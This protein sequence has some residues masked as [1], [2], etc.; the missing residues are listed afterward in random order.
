MNVRSSLLGFLLLCTLAP[1][2]A[3]QTP[4]NHLIAVLQTST[5]ELQAAAQLSS[6]QQAYAVVTRIVN[7]IL[8]AMQRMSLPYYQNQLTYLSNQQI[9]LTNRLSALQASV[10]NNANMLFRMTGAVSSSLAAQTANIGSI[11]IQ[12]KNSIQPSIDQLS[13]AMDGLA[14][15][16]PA[17]QSQV[18]SLLDLSQ[19]SITSLGSVEAALSDIQQKVTAAQS[20]PTQYFAFVF[21]ATPAT[22]AAPCKAVTVNINYPPGVGPFASPVVTV[23]EFSG[24]GTPAHPVPVNYITIESVSSTV[25]SL[26]VCSEDGLD[27]SRSPTQLFIEVHA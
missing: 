15:V 11:V 5:Q 25:L 27:P 13:N 24:I 7:E 12:Y 1:P 21:D 14:N 26:N 6:A 9:S 20:N 8:K 2:A 22:T 19:A 3:C 17:A 4:V 18:A 23:Y 16:V 10:S